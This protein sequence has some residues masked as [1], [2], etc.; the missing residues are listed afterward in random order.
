MSWGRTFGLSG[1]SA[2]GFSAV[3]AV[4]ARESSL[5][6]VAAAVRVIK[7]GTDAD[8]Y[9]IYVLSASDR[10]FRRGAAPT[11]VILESR[12]NRKSFYSVDPTI[13]YTDHRF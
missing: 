2:P 5:S 6:E 13:V 8:F 11:S 12:L 1:L 4:I 9:I 10:T 7:K 3:G